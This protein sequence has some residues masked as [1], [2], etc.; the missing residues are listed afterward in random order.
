MSLKKEPII[1]GINR[2]QDAS[3]TIFQGRHH[4]GSIHK[5]RITH[6]KH[7]WGKLKDLELYKKVFPILNQPIDL[8][9]ECFSSDQEAENEELYIQEI[10]ETFKVSDNYRRIHI[11]HHLAHLYS[12]FPVS[13]FNSSAAM[14]IDFQGSMTKDIL[15]DFP[16][17]KS[18]KGVEVAS[19]YSLVEN[20]ITCI[21]KHIWNEDRNIPEGLGTFYNMLSKCFYSGDGKEGKVMGLSSYGNPTLKLP[22]L[23]VIDGKVYIGEQWIEI[24]RD[25]STYKFSAQHKSFQEKANLAATGQLKFQEALLKVA[26]W[27]KETSN[28]ENL[29]YAGGCALNVTANSLIKKSSNFK[30]VYIPPAP[31]DGGTS[32]GCALY[33]LHNVFK[34]TSNFLWKEDYLGPVYSTSEIKK[35][36]ARYTDIQITE[37]TNIAEQCA[38]LLR[39]G[40]IMAIFQQGSEF[41]PRALGNRSILADPRYMITKFWINQ[42]IKGRE[43]YRPIAPMVLEEDV[44]EYFD[45][46]HPSPFMLYTA[47]IKSAYQGKLEAIAHIDNSARVQTVNSDSNPLIHQILKEFKKASGI[48]VICNTSFNLKGDTIVE[49][50]A[51]AIESFLKKPIHFLIM[52][53]YIIEKKNP[54]ENPLL[55]SD[56]HYHA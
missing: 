41:G 2:T 32:I 39:A 18:K 29:C 9:V 13:Q 31:N 45:T 8:I 51:E 12:A 11:S 54:P 33:G 38:E 25:A 6:I 47:Q 1:V 10:A 15:E 23:D 40:N 14:V 43:W 22:D 53:P 26:Q 36:L 7:D 28:E 49:T 17:A 16:E 44:Q 55:L 20:E 4:Y 35:T 30:N 3:I 27:L 21:Q 42:L 24:F 46:A 34:T 52:P 37:P 48:S 5:E 56:L 19:Y 50:P